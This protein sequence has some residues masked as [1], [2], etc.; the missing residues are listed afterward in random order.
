MFNSVTPA[1]SVSQT[2]A[3]S[4]PSSITP[5]TVGKPHSPSYIKV[6]EHVTHNTVALEPAVVFQPAAA[7]TPEKVVSSLNHETQNLLA[8]VEFMTEQCDVVISE[9]P[10]LAELSNSGKLPSNDVQIEKSIEP[11]VHI[12][13][14]TN[15]AEVKSQLKPT[16][17][18][19]ESSDINTRLAASKG[20]DTQD[21]YLDF[22][23]LNAIKY[24]KDS[25]EALMQV[26]KKFEA[27]F[28]QEMFK[29]MRSATEALGNEDNPLSNKS[30][31]MFQS[32]LDTQLATSMT[33]QT[34]FGL[35]EML[36]QQ[37]S[38]NQSSTSS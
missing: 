20:K 24:Q 2:Q 7:P 14:K 26:A 18:V 27:L 29:R 11:L 3:F 25:D 31:S 17:S 36:Y 1:W 33:K 38:N 6:M 8:K 5:S 28:V 35:A 37:L 10:D 22:N 13:S 15:E 19:Q 21:F 12:A 9:M 30:N 32:M 23:G 16:T 34:S 4:S